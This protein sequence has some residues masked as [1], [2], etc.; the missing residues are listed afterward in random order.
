MRWDVPA[1][2]EHDLCV[3]AERDRPRVAEPTLA[4]D[5]GEDG[6]ASPKAGDPVGAEGLPPEPE[7]VTES[8]P[9]VGAHFDHTGRIHCAKGVGATTGNDAVEG[10]AKRLRDTHPGRNDDNLPSREQLEVHSESTCSGHFAAQ[11]ADRSASENSR[12]RGTE[13]ITGADADGPRLRVRR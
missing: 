7:E 9:G 8:G 3:A 12:R 13:S 4:A 1:E 5:E 2:L 6:C 11:A 10:D